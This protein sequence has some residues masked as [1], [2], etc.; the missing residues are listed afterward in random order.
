MGASFSRIVEAQLAVIPALL[1]RATAGQTDHSGA[2]GRIEGNVGSVAIDFVESTM[3]YVWRRHLLTALAQS[4]SV[5]ED[6]GPRTVGFADLS[7]FSRISKTASADEIPRSSRSSRRQHSMS[8][9]LM[10]VAS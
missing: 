5:G 3:N 6:D 4:L 8:S 7:G 2:L 9:L 1:A 10:R